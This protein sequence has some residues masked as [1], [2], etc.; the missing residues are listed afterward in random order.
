MFHGERLAVV[1]EK[2]EIAEV[3][4]SFCQLH[5]GFNHQFVVDPLHPTSPLLSAY[6]VQ[7]L[8]AI[9]G[10]FEFDPVLEAIRHGY[11]HCYE[12]IGIFVAYLGSNTFRSRAEKFAL[13]EIGFPEARE[14]TVHVLALTPRPVATEPFGAP[15]RLRLPQ[16]LAKFR[17]S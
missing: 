5:P 15:V 16:G 14:I 6:E 13:F 17:S 12:Q 3:E 7:D 9:G 1:G 8:R 11:E 2:P 4:L 10:P